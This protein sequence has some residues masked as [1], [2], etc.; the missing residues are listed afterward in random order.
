LKKTIITI[1]GPAAAGKTTVSRLLSRELGF[2][3]VDTGAIYRALALSMKEK[4]IDFKDEKSVEQNLDA[5]ITPMGEKVFLNKKDVSSFIRTEEISMGASIISSYSS[6]RNYL[7]SVQRE[8]GLKFDSVFEGRD[9]G[10]KVFP[11]AQVKFYLDAKLE[12]RAERRFKQL[13]EKGEK[14]DFAKVFSDLEKR[15]I[16]DMTRKHSPL[17]P[18]RDSLII[19]S[20]LINASEVKLKMAEIIKSVIS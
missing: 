17:E 13:K 6:V 11:E 5:E 10:T 3:Y 7:L 8:I 18:A 20:T 12:T 15:D 16:Q 19:D 2:L 14:T 1:D 9:M 4:G